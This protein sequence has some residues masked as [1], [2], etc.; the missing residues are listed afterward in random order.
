MYKNSDFLSM[1]QPHAAGSL[2]STVGDLNT[3]YHSVLNDEIISA[4]SR[5]M[6]HTPETLNDGEALDYGFGWGIGNIQG[7]PM[8]QHGGGING[9]LS[10]SLVLPEE[11]LFVAVLSNCNCNPPGELAN[12]IAARGII[13]T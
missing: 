8:I 9:F 4:N 12:K 13:T 2:L 6:A 11:K 3:W 1:T 10:A 5:K 7:V